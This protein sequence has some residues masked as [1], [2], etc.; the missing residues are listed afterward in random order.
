MSLF[1]RPRMRD[2]TWDRGGTKEER[3]ERRFRPTAVLNADQLSFQQSLADIGASL[4]PGP[5]RLSPSG[6]RLV[7]AMKFVR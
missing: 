5:L 4:G 2:I 3:E 7:L 6:G 1:P